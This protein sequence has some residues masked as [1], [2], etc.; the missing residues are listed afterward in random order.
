MEVPSL[1]VKLEISNLTKR[2]GNF[3][4]L[5]Q[6]NLSIDSG[7]FVTLLGPSG[8]GKS[9]TIRMIAGLEKPDGGSITIDGTEVSRPNMVLPPESRNMGMVFQSYA[10]WPHMTV[11]ENVAF[12]LKMRKVPKETIP[13]RVRQMLDLVGL[14]GLEHRY[15]TQMSGGQ[16]QRIALARALAAEP[17]I[18]LLDE[19]LSNLD[20]KLRESMRFEIRSIQQRVGI[21]AIYVTHS[22][23]EALTMSDRIAVLN[24]GKLLQVGTPEEIYHRPI[25]RF[26]ANFV[27]LANFFEGQVVGRS[28]GH[29]LVRLASGDVIR[30]VDNGTDHPESVE[31]LVRPE[32]ISLASAD[33]DEVGNANGRANVLRGAVTRGDLQRPIYGVL[34]QAG[35]SRDGHPDPVTRRQEGAKGRRG[36]RVVFEPAAAYIIA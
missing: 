15:P 17:S 2:F 11:F 12:A 26:V 14:G 22:Q 33:G 19:P 6:L 8:C 36:R 27:G 5:D 30:V 20:A 10:V 24:Q 35:R 32:E 29:Y 16:Q 31:V 9:T 18:L 1:A 21:T 28:D 23:E 34:R 7:E 4:A 3:V 25:N 13:G